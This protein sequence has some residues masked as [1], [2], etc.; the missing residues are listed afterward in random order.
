MFHR[1]HSLKS[2]L[3]LDPDVL[4]ANS[5]LTELFDIL[6]AARHRPIHPPYPEI[7]E[8]MAPEIHRTLTGQQDAAVATEAMAT[9]IQTIIS[10]PIQEI[11]P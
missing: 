11:S 4:A 5:R 2:A 9:A 10:N 7:S 3:H 6:V 1:F 8:I